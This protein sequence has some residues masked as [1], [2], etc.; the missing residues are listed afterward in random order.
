VRDGGGVAP[1]SGGAAARR[2]PGGRG[3]GGRGRAAGHG[4]AVHARAPGHQG[5]A[6]GGAAQDTPLQPQDPR[7]LQRPPRH[8]AQHLLPDAVGAAAAVRGVAVTPGR[9][10]W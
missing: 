1:H 3:S 2:A 4:V 8:R 9:R 5:G 7:G 6:G 10:H